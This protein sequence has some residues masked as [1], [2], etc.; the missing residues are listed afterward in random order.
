MIRQAQH[1]I[2]KPATV[3]VEGMEVVCAAARIENGD[4]G[5]PVF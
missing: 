2:Q 1:H 4:P 5:R 3:A